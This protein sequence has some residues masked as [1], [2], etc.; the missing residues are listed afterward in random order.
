MAHGTTAVAA[1][2][3]PSKSFGGCIRC[4]EAGVNTR[5]MDITS[6]LPLLDDKPPN[7][8]RMV[9]SSISHLESLVSPRGGLIVKE[10]LLQVCGA[11]L[12]TTIKV[13]SGD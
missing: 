2:Q 10:Y 5:Q 11:A 4:V 9:N 13:T 6:S 7:V 12:G 1:V 3:Y 8:Y